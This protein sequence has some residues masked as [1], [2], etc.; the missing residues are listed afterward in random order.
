MCYFVEALTDLAAAICIACAPSMK[1]QQ[2]LQLQP[3]WQSKS[4]C[5]VMTQTALCTDYKVAQLHLGVSFCPG[6]AVLEPDDDL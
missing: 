3:V 6:Q 4:I 1:L 5:C 2:A